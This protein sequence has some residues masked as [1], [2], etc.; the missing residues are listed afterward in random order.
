VWAT[1]AATWR[2]IRYRD[3]WPGIDLA[4]SGGPGELKYEFTVAPGADPSRIRLG[5]RGAERT[6]LG[7]GGDVEVTTGLGSFVDAAPVAW[8]EVDGSRV[9]V[10][11]AWKDEGVRETDDPTW[12]GRHDFGFEL[13]AYDPTLPLVVDPAVLLSCGYVGGG[14]GDHANDVA[15]DADGAT[16]I[17][18]ETSSGAETFPVTVGPDLTYNGSDADAFVAKVSPDGRSV[19]YCGYLGGNSTDKALSIAVDSSGAAIVTGWTYSTDF[20]TVNATDSDWSGDSDAFVAKLSPAGDALVWSTYHGG[21]QWEEGRGIAVDGSGSIWVAGGTSTQ[22]DAFPVG[23]PLV[24]ALDPTHNGANDIFVSRFSPTGTLLYSTYLGGANEEEAN[25]V[26]VDAAGN[27]YIC[28]T[29]RSDETSFP[30]AV[31]PDLTYN[32]PSWPGNDGFVAKLAAAGSALVFAGYLGGSGGNDGCHGIAVDSGG[33]AYVTGDT[34]STEATFP[35]TVGPDPTFNGGEREAWL[36]RVAASGSALEYCGYIG[37]SGGETGFGVAVDRWGRAHVAGY[38]WTS[39]SGFGAVDAPAVPYGGGDDA[40]TARVAADG[41]SLEQNAFV[42]GTCSDGALGIAL[43]SDGVA[44]VAGWTCSADWN[45]VETV[46]P[47][48][49]SN[50]WNDAFVA[51]WHPGT[52]TLSVIEVGHLSWTPVAGATAYDLIAGDLGALRASAGSFSLA[53]LGCL[54]ENTG[55]TESF[56]P[57]DPIL[58]GEGRFYL[59]RDVR[60]QVTDPVRPHG[61][62][63]DASPWQVGLRDEEIRASG[64]ACAD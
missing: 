33:R 45:F 59:V 13:G 38:G 39:N 46:G 53:V 1:G 55:T 4:Y 56:S 14:G 3:L 25:D 36:A 63:S 42:H 20:P 48:L 35:V 26:A 54:E 23:F 50:G 40:F 12:P 49:T 27:T 5:Y 18:G 47:D 41:S 24:N 22:Q 15:V 51:Q 16:Y 7:A 31:G 62:Y 10:S 43:D 64:L 61:T 2:R 19:V 6:R 9:P 28:G 8:Q 32:G 57:P 30:V 37:A 34:N 44:H 52:T 60:G 17:A 11:V 58:P 29:T 21:G